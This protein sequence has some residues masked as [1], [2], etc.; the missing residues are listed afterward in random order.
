MIYQIA[1]E[2]GACATVFKESRLYRLTGGLAY[3]EYLVKEL[4]ERVQFLAPVCIPGENEML[5]LVKVHC[6]S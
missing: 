5:A 1:K 3:R 6:G 2:I 4:T